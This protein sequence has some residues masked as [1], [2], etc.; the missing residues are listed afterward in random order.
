MNVSKTY[1]SVRLQD[2]LVGHMQEDLLLDG[3]VVVLEGRH[4]R[5]V[6][7][8]LALRHYQPRLLWKQQQPE[9]N[10]W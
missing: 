9:C 10:E 3:L 2:L 6:L 7:L 5:L 4:G 1:C 8:R